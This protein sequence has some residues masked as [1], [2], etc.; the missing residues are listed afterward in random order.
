ME[1]KGAQLRNRI[2]A[3][4][5]FQGK[6]KEFRA[7][8]KAIISLYDI[9]SQAVHGARLH[10]T[11]EQLVSVTRL[12]SAVFRGVLEWAVHTAGEAVVPKE[13]EWIAELHKA[14]SDPKNLGTLPGV[15]KELCEHMKLFVKSFETDH[16]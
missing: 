15:T 2:P 13:Q 5:Q 8:N 12:L 1:D 7:I 3:V 11:E 4:L 16:E 6:G 9:R 10:A 14:T